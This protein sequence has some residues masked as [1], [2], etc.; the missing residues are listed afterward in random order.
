MSYFESPR[1]FTLLPPVIKNLLI[2]NGLF[3]LF[4]FFDTGARTWLFANLALFLPTSLN[5]NFPPDGTFFPT[6]IITYMFLHSPNDFGHLFFNMFALWMF[7]TMV[8]NIWGGRKFL[9]YYLVTGIG[10]GIAHLIYLYIFL[11]NNSIPL[12][13]L[14]PPYIPTVVGASGAVYGIMVAYAYLFP[15]SRVNLYFLI[16]VKAKYFVPG[17][18]ALDLIMGLSSRNDGVAH[19]AHLGGALVGFLYLVIGGT[20]PLKNY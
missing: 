1:K 19:F 15:N 6:Q 9:T 17:L 16:P 3:A 18:I 7:G 12:S 4:F 5:L 11:E 20:K 14:T 2:I 10:A 8:E 13:A